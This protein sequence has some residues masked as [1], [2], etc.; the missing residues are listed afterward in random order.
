MQSS[1]IYTIHD[2]YQKPYTVHNSFKKVPILGKYIYQAE[3]NPQNLIQFLNSCTRAHQ[4][5]LVFVKFFCQF[6]Y[7]LTQISPIRG[8]EV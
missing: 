2:H 4:L 1:A 6:C 3:K 8:N 7:D 5:L